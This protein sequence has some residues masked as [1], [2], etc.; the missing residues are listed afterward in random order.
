[1]KS[2]CFFAVVSLFIVAQIVSGTK[3]KAEP[4]EK[5]NLQDPKISEDTVPTPPV[6]TDS[7]RSKSEPTKD[8]ESENS[9]NDDE[10]YASGSV[11]SYCSYCM[12]GLFKWFNKVDFAL[13]ISAQSVW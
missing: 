7:E 2:V 11:C 1:M 9:A 10:K 13:G 8:S 3:E 12:V 6:T 4:M 5:P